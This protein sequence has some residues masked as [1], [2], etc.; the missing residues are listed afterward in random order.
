MKH[1]AT[2]AALNMAAER[3]AYVALIE[4]AELREAIR[5][6]RRRRIAKLAALVAASPIGERR[7]A[8][9]RARRSAFDNRRDCH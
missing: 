3:R 7:T 2:Q 9:R 8:P 4:S 6:I 5:P 1:N